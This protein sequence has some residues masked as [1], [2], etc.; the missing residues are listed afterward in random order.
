MEINNVIKKE[1]NKVE[2]NDKTNKKYLFIILVICIIVII[3]ISA[4]ACFIL[5]IYPKRCIGIIENNY[6]LQ[7]YYNVSKY[8]S[9]LD[10][11]KKYL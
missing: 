2:N 8:D 4:I 5:V 1:R 11:I 6:N 3:T 10:L 9:K 7:Q